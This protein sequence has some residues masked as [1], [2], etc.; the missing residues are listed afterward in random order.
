MTGADRAHHADLA[1]RLEHVD[2]HR[3]SEPDDSDGRQQGRHDDEEGDEDPQLA[4]DRLSL[5]RLR[6]GAGRGEAAVLE[7][8]KAPMMQCTIG[9]GRSARMTGF[10]HRPTTRRDARRHWN[11]E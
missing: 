1:R 5:S 3:A 2:G 10:P 8:A 4:R 7:P 9:A 11:P 6:L